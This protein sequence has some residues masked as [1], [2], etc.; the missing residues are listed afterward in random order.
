MSLRLTWVRGRFPGQSEIRK[1]KQSL[2]ASFHLGLRR[3]HRLQP[4]GKFFWKPLS[5][6]GERLLEQFFLWA[7]QILAGSLSGNFYLLDR[8][9]E[10]PIIR[11]SLS[12]VASCRIWIQAWHELCVYSCI[13][14]CIC[15][16]ICV[17][18]CLRVFVYVCLC[19]YKCICVC[20]FMLIC[21]GVCVYIC[22][23]IHIGICVLCIMCICVCVC[24]CICVFVCICICV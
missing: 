18:A 24:V 20:M 10:E 2:P 1:T 9:M 5:W 13:A 22:V 12:H 11:P 14:V 7:P 4:Y 23:F 16:C 6:K 19:I 17:Y 15:T 8:W 21:I 3:M